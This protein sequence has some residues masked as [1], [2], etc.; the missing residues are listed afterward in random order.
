M[1]QTTVL[2]VEDN[3]LN[4]ELLRDLLR[5][6]GYR[7]LESATAADGLRLVRETF[8]DLVLMDVRLP[9]MSGIEAVGRLRADPAV[10]HIPVVAVTASAMKG[11]VEAIMA[12][13]FDA[14][15]AK[16]FSLKPFLEKVAAILEGA[17]S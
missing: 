6:K 10:D 4:A 13:G 12:A 1:K 8:P 15:V 17:E 9:D 5:Y 16:P 3:A 7:T 11:D 2:I 14:F